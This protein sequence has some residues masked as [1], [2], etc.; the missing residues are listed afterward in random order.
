LQTRLIV[1]YG[2]TTLLEGVSRA[3]VVNH[4]DDITEFFTL[5]FQELTAFRRDNA[6]EGLAEKTSV[7]SDTAFPWEPQRRDKCTD[8]EEDQFLPEPA[9][10]C[11]SKFTQHPSSTSPLAESKSPPASDGASTPMGAELAYVPAKPAELAAHVL[12]NSPSLCSMRDVATSAHED[13]SPVPAAKASVESVRSE[14]WSLCSIAGELGP[15]SS[16]VDGHTNAVNQ[17]SEVPS[18][19]EPSPAPKDP[20]WAVPSCN[21]AEV[22]STTEAVSQCWP[23][24]P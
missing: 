24:E 8:T 16:Q 6:S 15:S 1:P 13:A 11:S 4:P 20:L 10:Q 18:W 21:K 7:F 23:E 17:A 12:G 19:E 5:Y 3:A 22:T 9:I 2:L 14:A